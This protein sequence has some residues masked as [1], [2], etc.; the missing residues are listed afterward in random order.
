MGGKLRQ[1]MS[2]DKM[3]GNDISSITVFHLGINLSHHAVLGL[4]F[5]FYEITSERSSSD[6]EPQDHPRRHL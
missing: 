1:A 6:S 5:S 4:S 2:K 3:K